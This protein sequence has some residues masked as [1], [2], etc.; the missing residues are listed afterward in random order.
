MRTQAARSTGRL[1]PSQPARNGPEVAR[2]DRPVTIIRP[3]F[4]PISP[5]LRQEFIATA[6]YFK[7]LA[8]GFQPGHEVED[9]LAAEAEFDELVARR[10]G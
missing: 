1:E 3:K 6:A 5:Q 10:Y 2:A 8:R 7:A 4:Q 9:W